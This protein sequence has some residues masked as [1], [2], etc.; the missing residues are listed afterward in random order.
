MSVAVEHG[1]PSL[2]LL[3]AIASCSAAGADE[4]P[5]AEAGDFVGNGATLQPGFGDVA[6]TPQ[7]PASSMGGSTSAPMLGSGGAASP[8][9]GAIDPAVALDP[10]GVDP[11]LPGPPAISDGFVR[12]PEPTAD[13]ASDTGPFDVDSYTAGLRDGPAYG[14]QTLYRPTDAEPPFAGVVVVPG[15]L[16]LESSTAAW[17]P[18]LASHGIVALTIGTNAGG[19]LP[20]VRARALMDGIETIKAENDREGSPLEGQIAVDRFAIMGWSMG[21]G[22]T[23]IA[24]NENPGLKAAISLAAWSPGATFASDQVPTLLFAGTADPLAGGQSQGFY[25]S[26]PESTP[27][28]LYEVAGGNHSVANAPS[29]AGG[30]IGL[31]GLSWMKVFLEG[32]ER[33][34]QFLLLPPTQEADFLINL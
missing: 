12:G 31:Y 8:E 2:F 21:G 11:A 18:F 15:F 14:T 6:Q 23:L 27:K 17:G 4:G 30:E 9:T 24:A 3:M 19:D 1:L 29:G 33:Y 10:G 22:G 28:L 34:R 26:I 5:D 25:A 32:D 7:L 20:D 13:S 16:A